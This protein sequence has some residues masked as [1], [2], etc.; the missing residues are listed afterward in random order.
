MEKFRTLELDDF[1][2]SFQSCCVDD[3]EQTSFS[4]LGFSSQTTGTL[5]GEAQSKESLQ[6]FIDSLGTSEDEANHYATV[7]QKTFRGFMTR[8][9]NKANI[10]GEEEETYTVEEGEG[11]KGNLTD[12]EELESETENSEAKEIGETLPALEGPASSDQSKVEESK[13]GV[14]NDSLFVQNFD[15]IE[16][17]EELTG[18]E[19]EGN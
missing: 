19:E 15:D 18:E 8:K 10:N 3:S 16:E 6:S 12:N 2:E 4:L 9:G 11:V 14:D 5:E 7:I 13:E 1:V 17:E